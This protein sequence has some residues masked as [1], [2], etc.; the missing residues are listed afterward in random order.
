M[1]LDQTFSEMAVAQE[2]WK[3]WDDTAADGLDALKW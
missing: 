2:E 3:V 1:S